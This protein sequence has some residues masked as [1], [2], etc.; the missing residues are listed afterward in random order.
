ML[1]AL[2]GSHVT[3][4]LRTVYHPMSRNP[5]SEIRQNFTVKL[6]TYPSP[7]LTLKLTSYLGQ[8]FGLGEGLVG[9]FP[10]TNNDPKFLLVEF[11]LQLWIGIQNPSFTDKE[12]RIPEHVKDLWRD[13]CEFFIFCFD[14]YVVRTVRGGKYP[15]NALYGEAPPERGTFFQAS[16]IGKGRQFHLLNYM[17]E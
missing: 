10:R 8:N 6:P 11:G 5:D 15:Y 4:K 17:K 9:S 1:N 12:S 2:L 7:K 3:R 13:A 14:I 16:G